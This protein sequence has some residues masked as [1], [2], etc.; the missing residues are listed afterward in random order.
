MRKLIAPALMV[1]VIL[2]AGCSEEEP[3]SGQQDGAQQ[4]AAPRDRAQAGSEKPKTVVVNEG[5]SQREEDELNQ[6]LAELEEEVDDG[7]SVQPTQEPESSGESD[8]LA[9]A[10]SYYAAASAGDYVQTY[11]ELSASSQS[12][13]TEGQWVAAN[14]ALQSDSASYTIDS[15]DLVDDATAEVYLTV[16]SSDGSSSERATRFVSEGGTWKHELTQAEYDLFAGATASATA[17]ASASTSASPSASDNAGT[18]LVQIVI[19]SDKPADVSINDDSLDWFVTEE[20]TG[21]KTY[22]REI[23]ENSGLSVSA[24]TDAYV[25]QT[26]IEVYEEGSLVAQDSDSNG[27]AMINY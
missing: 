25:A 12:Q 13:F 6:R 16:T 5:M 19:S 15:A 10:Q 14:T 7:S 3:T 8:A 11:D 18:K 1:T 26:T 21:T 22:E 2:T 9:A 27:F 17:S 4:T 20:I 24:T 23:A